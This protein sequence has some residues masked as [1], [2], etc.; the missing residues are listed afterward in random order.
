MALLASEHGMPSEVRRDARSTVAGNAC[1]SGVI[2]LAQ[3]AGDGLDDA[4]E[5][6][7]A[8]SREGRVR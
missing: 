5:L 2:G 8:L 3:T 7:E 1:A 4:M 6:R